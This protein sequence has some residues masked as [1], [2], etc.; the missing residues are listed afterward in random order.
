[1][2][3]MFIR[4]HGYSPTYQEIGEMIDS[5]TCSAFNIVLRLQEKGYITMANSRQRTI[6]VVKNNDG[7]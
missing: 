3:D 4:E 2:I 6:R 5:P 1:M 7:C